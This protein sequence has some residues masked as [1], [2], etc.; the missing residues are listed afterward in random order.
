MAQS[1]FRFT[2]PYLETCVSWSS[3]QCR[4]QYASTTW[5][6]PW[7][8]EWCLASEDPATSSRTALQKRW[9]VYTWTVVIF[10]SVKEWIRTEQVNEEQVVNQTANPRQP[11][12]Y[13]DHQTKILQQATM[14]SWNVNVNTYWSLNLIAC[15]KLAH[16][17]R[18]SDFEVSKPPKRIATVHLGVVDS[19]TN[20]LEARFFFLIPLMFARKF[21]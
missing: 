6:C 4:E 11:S 20:R 19:N 21:Q 10:K 18:F 8:A 3:I 7:T 13:G 5:G 17:F 1:F 15:F 9:S 14:F 2:R 12:E 16:H